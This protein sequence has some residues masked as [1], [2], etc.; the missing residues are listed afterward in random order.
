MKLLLILFK[1]I[2]FFNYC[3]VGEVLE[4]DNFKKKEP[5]FIFTYPTTLISGVKATACLNLYD[6]VLPTRALVDIKVNKQHHTTN[7]NVISD[8]SCFALNVPH[9][10]Q[11]YKIAANVDL[12]LQLNG[13]VHW[14]NADD[15]PFI[16]PNVYTT[17]IETDRSFYRMGEKVKIRFLVLDHNLRPPN[18]YKISSATLYNPFGNTVTVWKNISTELGLA[19]EEFRLAA[20]T[21]VGKWKIEASGYTRTFHVKRYVLPR[22]QVKLFTPR[23]IYVGTKNLY[24]YVCTK[25]PHGEHVQGTTLLKIS[26]SVNSELKELQKSKEIKNGCVKFRFTND[27]FQ[28]Y[29]AVLDRNI[30]ITASVTEKGTNVMEMETLKV[31]VVRQEYQLKFADDQEYFQPGFPYRGKLKLTNVMIPLKN[32]VIQICCEFAVKRVWNIKQRDCRNFTVNS[33]N[34]INFSVMPTRENVVQLNLQALPVN[35]SSDGISAVM[36]LKRWYSKSHNSIHI[37]KHHRSF[38][39]CGSTLHYTISYLSDDLKDSANVTFNYVLISRDEIL[40]LGHVNHVPRKQKLN[41]QEMKNIIGQSAKFVGSERAIDKFSFR[42]SLDNN[43]YTKANLLVYYVVQNEVIAANA[44]INVEKC[45][46]NNVKAK[47][48]NSRIHPGET[49][50]LHLKTDGNSLCAV[51][52]IDKAI[53]FMGS[54]KAM[55]P[56]SILRSF[57]QMERRMFSYKRNCLSINAAERPANIRI[58]PWDL[59][60]KRQLPSSTSNNFIVHEHSSHFDT[61]ELFKKSNIGVISNMRMISKPCEKGQSKPHFLI[62]KP[63]AL[64]YDVEHE[65]Y[66]SAIRSFF[67]ESWLWDLV[68]V[69]KG[70]EAILER[71]VPDSITTWNTNVMCVSP[72]KGVG[73][74]NSLELTAFKSFFLDVLTPYSIKKDEVLHLPV[75]V[76]NYL[77]HSIP[78]KLTLE[79]NDGLMLLPNENK[80]ISLCLKEDNTETHTFRLKFHRLGRHNV[81]ATALVDYSYPKDCGPEVILNRRDAVHKSI[82][83]ESEGYPAEIVRS[84]VLCANGSLGNNN[85]WWDIKLPKDIVLDSLRSKIIINSDLLGPTIQNLEHLLNV[86]TGC[87]E[88]V[89]AMIT[90]NLYVLR[91]LK[92]SGRLTKSLYQRA[93]RNMKIGYQRILD[94]AH[95]D[96]SFSAFGYHDPDGSM[97]L[98]AFVVRTLKQ[99]KEYIHVDEN[100]IRK[101]ITWI[102]KH[103]LENGCFHPGHHVFH[104]LGGMS[105]ENS[106]AALTA[107]VLI[108][109]LESNTD[110]NETIRTNAKYCIRGLH[111]PDKYTLAISAYALYLV[112][113]YSNADRS[114]EKLLQLATKEGDL[115]WWGQPD[116]SLSVSIE[117]TS[118][119]LMSLLHKNSSQNLYYAN[120]I[121]KWLH[122]KLGAKGGFTTTQDTSVALDALSRYASLINTGQPQMNITVS[123]QSETKSI[124]VLKEDR[125]KMT[126][127][128]LDEVPTKVKI[129]VDGKGC[130]LT[131]AVITYNSFNF[132]STQAFRLAVDVEPVSEIDKCSVAIISPCVAYTGPGHS[133]M[134]VLEVAMPSGYEP[135]RDSLFELANKDN[136][137]VKKFEELAN[138]VVL[139]FTEL[140]NEPVCVPFNINENTFVENVINTTIKLYDYYKPEL[141][142]V[143]SY[144]VNTC[145]SNVIAPIPAL[146]G[147]SHKNTTINIL[148]DQ[149]A[150]GRRKRHGDFLDK[151]Y[152]ADFD[153]DMPEGLEGIT[154]IYILP[155]DVI[156][157]TS[158][159]YT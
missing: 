145:E 20:D 14:F 116:L 70:G 92:R 36:I 43:I 62:Y 1:L 38:P 59:R 10:N 68:L 143:K 125:M 99:I 8:N 21:T 144:K 45:L 47:W 75:V 153:L 54:H 149:I 72:Y 139:Y 117:M 89:M 87:G 96:G 60:K 135:D 85:V 31:R 33:E 112:E 5:G 4:S 159:I 156:N 48:S 22:F 142:V 39:K 56:S 2:Y 132:N 128:D 152:N 120:S 98:T 80:T 154:P 69:G 32:E 123:S 155:P 148:H 64:E 26:Y 61:Y 46:P 65:D 53:T 49:A 106:T 57:V 129:S 141:S 124:T 15:I 74:S 130:V 50:S 101:A 27:D 58:N 114:L 109:L 63:N 119:V 76:H 77:N 34:V 151:F 107:Y 41:M 28:F 13:T 146:P 158:F 82:L 88:Q 30:F 115:L 103:Q 118:Y 150:T 11:P 126:Q 122:S 136:T 91:Y 7:I 18:G 133:N 94:Y 137:R 121:V 105:T 40:K 73:L 86:P 100:V 55:S 23:I 110:L 108:S 131:Q 147:A 37:E 17:F 3:V 127:I 113:W 111:Q 19:Q 83:V 140:T 138:R 104:E 90:P 71:K 52:S 24:F 97:F 35:R 29:D 12:Q 134:A 51:S 9:L 66:G 102:T 16:Y 25:Y 6:A 42:I 93:I 95:A 79:D 67:P 78:V 84:T 44:D 81:S 157:N